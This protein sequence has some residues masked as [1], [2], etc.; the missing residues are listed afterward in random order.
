MAFSV[1][2]FSVWRRCPFLPT[3]RFKRGINF[4]GKE[5]PPGRH[6]RVRELLQRDSGMG[7]YFL[8][9]FSGFPGGSG[10]DLFEV[11]V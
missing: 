9:V 6:C 3:Q 7:R 2:H 5:N 8:C 11:R 1:R 4:K 10:L